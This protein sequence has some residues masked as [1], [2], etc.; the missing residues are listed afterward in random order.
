MRHLFHF[1]VLGLCTSSAGS[2]TQ[3]ISMPVC[4]CKEFVHGLVS[5]AASGISS[6]EICAYFFY[7]L[8]AISLL[9][10]RFVCDIPSSTMTCMRYPFFYYDLYA[11]S[12]LQVLY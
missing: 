9:L 8:C 2:Q 1:A 5:C 10:L 6:I 12:L 7:G 4:L 3:S 11:I